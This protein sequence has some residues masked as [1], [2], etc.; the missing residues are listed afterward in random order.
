MPLPQKGTDRNT[1][2]KTEAASRCGSEFSRKS[3]SGVTESK[4]RLG[5]TVIEGVGMVP[6]QSQILLGY[7]QPLW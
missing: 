4:G 3:L 6:V 1:S 2:A 5:R 7:F